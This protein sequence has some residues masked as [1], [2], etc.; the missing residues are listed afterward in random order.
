MKLFLDNM[1]AIILVLFTPFE[2][3]YDHLQYI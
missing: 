2:R 3:D 1:P